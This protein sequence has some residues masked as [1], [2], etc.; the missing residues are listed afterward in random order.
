M[1]D[2][3]IVTDE[4]KYTILPIHNFFLT[5]MAATPD[6]FAPVILSKASYA[7]QI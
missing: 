1:P 6:I 7:N 5:Q 4:A 2:N 3:W